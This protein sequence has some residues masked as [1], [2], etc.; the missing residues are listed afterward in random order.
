MRPVGAAWRRE[1]GG[2]SAPRVLCVD[3]TSFKRG[4]EYITV[5]AD[6]K[7]GVVVYVADGR[8]RAAPWG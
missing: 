3:E 7:R 5:A 8:E 6:A 2:E 1:A 4:H